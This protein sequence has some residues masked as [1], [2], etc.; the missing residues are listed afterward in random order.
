MIA[1]VIVL[2]FDTVHLFS[3][4]SFWFKG[5]LSSY[6]SSQSLACGRGLSLA[7][8]SVWEVCFPFREI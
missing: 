1:C 5:S 2:V 3:R 6:F 4:R 8:S 7:V